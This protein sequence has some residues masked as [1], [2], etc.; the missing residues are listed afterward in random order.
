MNTAWNRWCRNLPSG[1]ALSL[2]ENRITPIII[3][4][5][6]G[7]RNVRIQNPYTCTTSSDCIRLHDDNRPFFLLRGNAHAYESGPRGNIHQ[8]HIWQLLQGRAVGWKCGTMPLTEAALAQAKPLLYLS[9]SLPQCM[10]TGD[11][12]YPAA[13][14]PLRV[15]TPWLTILSRN[16]R[17]SPRFLMQTSSS[18]R[19]AYLRTH[20]S[21]WVNH[22]YQPCIQTF[23]PPPSPPPCVTVSP[24][25][26]SVLFMYH[27]ASICF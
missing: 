16:T 11:V 15:L 4:D 21:I 24:C 23:R 1:T 9:W 22:F 2:Y 20:F 18:Q 27:T 10:G 14:H 5:I 25:I 3:T 8:S 17:K 12:C 6:T 19:S 13:S 7:R 26:S